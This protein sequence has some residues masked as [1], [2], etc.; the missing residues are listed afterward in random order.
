MPMKEVPML[1]VGDVVIDTKGRKW[2]VLE[3]HGR[4]KL[5]SVKIQPLGWNLPFKKWDWLLTADWWMS[6]GWIKE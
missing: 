3:R 6:H 5:Y 2:S 1:K 4:G